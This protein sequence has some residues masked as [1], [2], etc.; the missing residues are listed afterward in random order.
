MNSFPSK[1]INILYLRDTDKV[2]GPGKTMIN[3]HRTLDRNRFSLVLC[4]TGSGEDGKNAFCESARSAGADVVHFQTGGFFGLSAVLRLIK[5]I[6]VRQID[7]LQTH[8]A[9]TRRIGIIAARLAG[10]P[11]ISSVHGWIRNSRKQR[12]GVVLD[13][14]L[15]RF[16]EKVIVMSELMKKEIVS[17]GVPVSKVMVLHNAILL[18]DYR[19]ECE[20][21]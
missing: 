12:L 2:C 1:K 7:I 8:D 14:L 15:I 10:I 5:M 21:T 18:D 17:A 4:V 16:S 11:H 13:K 9:Q 3:T 6:K 20:S 19:S